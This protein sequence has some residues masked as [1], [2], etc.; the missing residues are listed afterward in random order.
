MRLGLT[1]GNATEVV[2]GDLK[3]GAEVIVGNVERSAQAPRP[4]ADRA[5]AAVLSRPDAPCRRA[6]RTLD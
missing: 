1:D 5:A 2:G 4:S 3:E 6:Q